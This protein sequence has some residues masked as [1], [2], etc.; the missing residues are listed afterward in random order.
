L[1]L[2]EGFSS[3]YELSDYDFKSE[4]ARVYCFLCNGDCDYFMPSI[5][6]CFPTFQWGLVSQK[7]LKK[8]IDFSLMKISHT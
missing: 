5:F 8:E 7:Y 3:M 2:G 1:T 6:M 4:K